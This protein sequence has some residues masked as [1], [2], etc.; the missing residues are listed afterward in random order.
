MFGHPR[1]APPGALSQEWT[2]NDD[3]I[4]RISQRL[5][6]VLLT[7]WIGLYLWRS[8][9]AHFALETSAFDLSI[10][11]YALWSLA[12]GQPG[13]V[14][15]AGHSIFSHHFMPILVVLVPFYAPFQSATFLIVLQVLA[16]AAAGALFYRLQLAIGLRWPL[17]LALLF[18]FLLSRWSHSAVSSVFYPES[19]QPLLTL[20]LVL[21]WNQSRAR[22][23]LC[24][25]LLLMTKEDAALYVAAFGVFQ[26]FYTPD[27]RRRAIATAVIGIAW[28][29]AAVFL[30]IPA[31]RASEGLPASNPL[32]EA[33]YGG[34][35]G[36]VGIP[37]AV[38]R[39]TSAGSART[40]VRILAGSGFLPL[41]GLPWLLPAVP[42]I[43]AN[44]AANSGQAGL[45]A[46]YAWAILPWMF[47]AAAHG[48]RRLDGLSRAVASTLACLV[49]I[50]TV[51]DSPAIRGIPHTRASP[52]GAAIRAQLRALEGSSILAMPN[53]IPHLPH[54]STVFSFGSI[55]VLPTNPDLVLLTSIGSIWPLT[56]P[57][58]ADQIRQ[59]QKR[60]EYEQ[61]LDGPLT[62]FRLRTK[63]NRDR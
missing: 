20:A 24:M 14:P 19:L 6:L 56:P 42:G 62:V 45:S 36:S 22:L 15:F 33:R 60:G 2:D 35:D 25:A 9:T 16:M 59:F 10:F 61:V 51:F 27:R 43:M 17:A 8:L 44:L 57:E 1:I 30:V 28:L 34:R 40:L 21:V 31:S 63:T 13:L 54:Q 41:L 37:E 39:V 3:V 4:G 32:L 18:V 23:L 55:A 38:A 53:L 12:H 50:A 29:T 5:W 49:C 52:E 48:L 11:D 7:A 46:H 47:I 26:W 58:V